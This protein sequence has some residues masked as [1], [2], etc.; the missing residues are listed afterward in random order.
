MTIELVVRL[1]LLLLLFLLCTR[2]VIPKTIFIPD[3]PSSNSMI[4]FHDNIS[5]SLFT[6]IF[7]VSIFVSII[8]LPSHS[9]ES[10]SANSF[11][12]VEEV[13]YQ[14]YP[15]TMKLDLMVVLRQITNIVIYLFLILFLLFHFEQRLGCM[16]QPVLVRIQSYN[17]IMIM[18]NDDEMGV[19]L[20]K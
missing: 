18:N 14:I 7:F 16:Y 9:S 4:K 8:F 11:Q 17:N 12:V 2:F 5:M 13:I 19:R 3:F 15:I 6:I 10:F 1:I 20:E